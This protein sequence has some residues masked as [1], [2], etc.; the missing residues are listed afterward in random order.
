MPEVF[1]EEVTLAALECQPWPDHFEE[2]AR[3]ETVIEE[4]P[5]E[6]FEEGAAL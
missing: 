4:S 3:S 2:E 6:A 1:D 5:L